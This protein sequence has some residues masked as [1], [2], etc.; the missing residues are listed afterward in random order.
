MLFPG[1]DTVGPA[2]RGYLRSWP[3][4]LVDLAAFFMVGMGLKIFQMVIL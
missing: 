4:E 2:Y 3:S 1:R